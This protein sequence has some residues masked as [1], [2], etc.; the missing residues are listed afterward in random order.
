MPR[1]FRC[2]LMLLGSFRRWIA[3]MQKLFGDHTDH[4]RVIAAYRQ[5]NEKV[6]DTIP[7]DRLLVYNVAEGW[8]PLC[9]F[10]EVPV[11][12]TPFP[13]TNPREEFRTRYGGEPSD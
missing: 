11:P 4:D 5:N 6:R 1:A 8:E 7:V 9:R 12:L 3:F 10:L 2:R 13:R